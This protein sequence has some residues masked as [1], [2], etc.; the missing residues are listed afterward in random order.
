[1]LG[2]LYESAL[3]PERAPAGKSLLRCFVG[4][5]RHPERA[6]LGD[7]QMGSQA[8]QDLRSLGVM[9]GEPA[10]SQVLRTAGIPQM[11]M[12]HEACLDSLKTKT[13][14]KV[15][16]IGHHAIGLEAVALEAQALASDFS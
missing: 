10:F 12:G 6:A 4:G 7:A 5:S 3:F 14:G 11:E 9:E 2:C 15:L 16:G 8:W 1:M 13:K